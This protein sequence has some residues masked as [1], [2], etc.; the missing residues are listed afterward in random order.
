MRKTKVVSFLIILTLM[1]SFIL[2][3]CADADDYARITNMD[4]LA[5]VVDEPG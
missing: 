3:G 5:V 4:Y 2:T 1:L